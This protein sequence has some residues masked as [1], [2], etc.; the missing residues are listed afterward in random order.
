MA[1]GVTV[2][3]GTSLATEGDNAYELFVIEAGEADVHKGG[4]VVRTLGTGEIGLLATSS[5]TRRR[6]DVHDARVAMFSCEYKQLEGRTPGLANSLR[7]TMASASPSL[8]SDPS[9]R[10]VNDFRPGGVGLATW[11]TRHMTRR[12]ICHLLAAAAFAAGCGD[13]DDG[14]GG[15]AR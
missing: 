3:A 11:N 9:S 6:R 5:R 4:Q 14:G 15:Q 10:S 12:G 1:G 8:R 7:K 2:N 13:D